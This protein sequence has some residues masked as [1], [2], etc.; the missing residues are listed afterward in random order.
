MGGAR[1]FASATIFVSL[2]HFDR[3]NLCQSFVTDV[4]RRTFW[5]I[6]FVHIA[7]VSH[8]LNQKVLSGIP[9][10]QNFFLRLVIS[11]VSRN[12]TQKHSFSPV[13]CCVLLPTNEL[14]H[15]IPNCQTFSGRNA[16]FV[17]AG[18]QPRD[19]AVNKKKAGFPA[20][21]LNVFAFQRMF[22]CKSEWRFTL[23]ILS[24]HCAA[25]CTSP[26]SFIPSGEI[27]FL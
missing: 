18:R 3:Q 8:V 5:C 16:E 27:Q 25:T 14:Y 10:S 22:S 7:T 12:C 17:W 4:D 19:N 24:D 21:T 15:I 1:A 2:F 23:E 20:P 11:P 9:I 6:I 26:F 13:L